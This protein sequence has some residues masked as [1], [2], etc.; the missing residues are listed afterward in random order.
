MTFFLN[1][2]DCIFTRMNDNFIRGVFVVVDHINKL[3][4]LLNSLV[5]GASLR[6]AN[7]VML[8]FSNIEL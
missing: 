2:T 4:I 7:T 6:K 8:L 5:G 1:T 3:D